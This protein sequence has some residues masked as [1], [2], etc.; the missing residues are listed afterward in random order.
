MALEQEKPGGAEYVG[1][2]CLFKQSR[3]WQI[4]TLRG[5]EASIPEQL[6]QYRGS[7]KI[8]RDFKQSH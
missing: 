1:A 8:L 3:L 6:A 4:S 5:W 7:L 2:G